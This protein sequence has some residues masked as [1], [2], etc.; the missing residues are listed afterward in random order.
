MATNASPIIDLDTGRE[1]SSA[2][3]PTIIPR[4]AGNQVPSLIGIPN[5][6][7]VTVCWVAAG[8]AIGYYICHKSM[9]HGRRR[10]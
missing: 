8:I 3:Q 1:T 6:L 9:S 2:P 7:A 4:P 10:D 5:Q